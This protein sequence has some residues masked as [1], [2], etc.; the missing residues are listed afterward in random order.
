MVA[1]SVAVTGAWTYGFT[2]CMGRRRKQTDN[3]VRGR[4]MLTQILATFPHT[5]NLEHQCKTRERAIS[6]ETMMLHLRFVLPPAVSGREGKWYFSL[7]L[8]LANLVMTVLLNKEET[9]VEAVRIL[10]FFCYA[11]SWCMFEQVVLSH[12]K[13]QE[14]LRLMENIQ[15]Y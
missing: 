5:S 15:M 11:C 13:C 7:L 2:M 12:I 1:L 10:L 8:K 6:S 3:C 14:P 9:Q 4:T